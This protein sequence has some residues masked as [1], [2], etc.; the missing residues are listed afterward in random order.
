MNRFLLRVELPLYAKTV[1]DRTVKMSSN[2]TNQQT[3]DL[4]F[5]SASSITLDESWDINETAQVLLYIR[6]ISSMCPKKE[7]LGLL[8]LKVQTC[9]EDITNAAIEYIEKDNFPF[10]KI[11]SISTDAAKNI[12]RENF[13]SILKERN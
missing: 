11:V 8:P 5:L 13:V 6:F 4:N 3:G 9:G 2:I 12:T 10:D 1:K 7:L